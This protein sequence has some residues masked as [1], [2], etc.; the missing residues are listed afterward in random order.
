[1]ATAIT[2]DTRH[3][4]RGLRELPPAADRLDLNGEWGFAGGPFRGHEAASGRPVTRV[5]G[6]VIY[7]GLVPDD[8]VATFHR[9]FEVPESW[10]GRAVFLHCDGAYGRAE[11]NL[12]GSWAGSH[13][14]G[15]T[16]FDVELTPFLRP[17]A[18]ELAVTLTEY[19][20]YAVLDDMSWYAHM[21]LL[22]I[23]RDVFLF[24]TPPLHLGQLDIDADWDPELASGSL[25]LG[26][27]VIN[28][29]PDTRTYDLEVTVRGDG[30]DVVH[31]SSRHGS[32]D[33]S[34]GAREA[35]A[36]GPLAVRPWSAEE[37]HQYD[38]EVVIATDGGAAP[39]YHRRIGF[40]RVETRAN[41]LLV[42]GAPIRIRGVNR[43]D[44]RILKGRALSAE[45]MRADVL[46]LRR[47]NVNV[48]RTSHYPPSPHLLEVCDEVGM[49]VFEQPPICFSGGFDDHHWT[50]TN[51]DARLIPYLLDVTAETV[52][53]DQGHLGDRLGPRQQSRWGGLR[54]PARAGPGDGPEPPDDLSFD[55]NELGDENELVRKPAEDRPD[56][57]SYHYPGWDRTWQEDLAWLGSY[58]QPVVLDEYAP[59]F[60]PC[61]RGPGEGYG[62]AID[63]GIRDYW[64]AGYQPFM[65]AALQDHGVIGGLIWGGFGEVFAI[66]LDLTVGEGPWAHLPASATSGRATTTRPSPG[67]SGAATATGACS[68]PGTGHAPSSGTSTRCT[69]RSAC[70]LPTSP[71]RA[72]GST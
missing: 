24:S 67:C 71:R 72:I 43:H 59:L 6:H 32:V 49:F 25:A 9:T 23:W 37:P 15:A 60:A 1:M 51:E 45:D 42:N 26:V 28:L 12:N 7:D 50:R 3:V 5:P 46:N 39:A 69:R 17:G 31:R 53:R 57:R 30:G 22:G 16:S 19:T 13:G 61:L 55:L 18:N 66:P 14:S 68:T 10:S 65:E 29:D 58:D 4:A 38:L 56:I 36:S 35:F 54:R 64:G 34:G 21:S 40:R 27:D 63:P 11:V 47:A 62:L 33:R 8:G 48:I 70:Q 2:V 44:S 20:P 52:A 41:Q